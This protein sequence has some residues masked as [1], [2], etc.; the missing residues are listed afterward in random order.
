MRN[1]AREYDVI[2]NDVTKKFIT[3]SS[4]RHE[5]L[6]SQFALIGKLYNVGIFA[7][8][9]RSQGYFLFVFFKDLSKVI[10]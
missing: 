7:N 2:D 3:K 10:L 1:L 8:F 4:K 9:V 5:K 6:L